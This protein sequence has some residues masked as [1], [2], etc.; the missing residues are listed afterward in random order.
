MLMNSEY[1]SNTITKFNVYKFKAK[2]I[3]DVDK[4]RVKE[5]D[6]SKK[7][8]NTTRLSFKR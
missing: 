8:E 1:V 2:E 3:R 4:S 6:I 7:V 5:I